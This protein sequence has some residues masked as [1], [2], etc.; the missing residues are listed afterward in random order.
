MLKQHM[1]TRSDDDVDDKLIL[2]AHPLMALLSG[3]HLK[4]ERRGETGE[5]AGCETAAE[6]VQKNFQQKNPKKYFFHHHHH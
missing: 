4:I 5:N 3:F 1:P 6:K 2:L